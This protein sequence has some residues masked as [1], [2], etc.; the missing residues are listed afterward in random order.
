MRTQDSKGGEELVLSFAALYVQLYVNTNLL[1]CTGR[2]S[3]DVF[4]IDI[5]FQ[6]IT[7]CIISC[8]TKINKRRFTV[9]TSKIRNYK[10]L[11]DDTKR[12]K[13]LTC[14]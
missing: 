8:Q 2:N 13:L 3:K 10:L 14:P 7:V 11:Y 5:K 1:I 6:S 4:Q 12:I 9:L